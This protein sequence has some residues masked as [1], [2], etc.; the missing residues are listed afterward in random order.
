MPIGAFKLADLEGKFV[1]GPSHLDTDV[2]LEL[3]R[4]GERLVFTLTTKHPAA[5]DRAI[6]T[7]LDPAEAEALRRELETTDG[8]A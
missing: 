8:D 6:R 4:L 2:E 3:E 7:E 5:P 1:D